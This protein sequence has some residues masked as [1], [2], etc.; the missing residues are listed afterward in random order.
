VP[1]ASNPHG[2]ELFR[3]EPGAAVLTV[4]AR[5][6]E[7]TLQIAAT[8]PRQVMQLGAGRFYGHGIEARTNRLSFGEMSWDP[9]FWAR[10][11]L[12]DRHF[13]LAF[14][15]H[16]R[17]TMRFQNAAFH[18]DEIAVVDEG[19]DFDLRV[20]GP[21]QMIFVLVAKP[22][23]LQHARALLQ[24]PLDDWI[25]DCRLT[26]SPPALLSVC[27]PIL[28][29]LLRNLR[30]NADL[31]RHPR[32]SRSIETVVLDTLMSTVEPPVER[33]SSFGRRQIARR[34]EEYLRAQLAE[35]VSLRELCAAAG[36]SE[37]TLHLAFIESFGMSPKQLLKTLRLNRA[38]QAL[39]NPTPSTTVTDV[40]L[41]WG[42]FHFGRFSIAYRE[43]FGE[44]PLQ[45]L[46]RCGAH[47]GASTRVTSSSGFHGGNA[48]RASASAPDKIDLNHLS[49]RSA[50]SS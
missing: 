3:S 44:T 22:L 46:R 31:L 28:H 16:R 49:S 26:A 32:A 5:D 41:D 30:D 18:A 25:A 20:M 10:G 35:P 42:F 27:G 40:A 48:P 4:E 43:M 19:E 29:A 39:R 13:A 23:L 1:A 34:A 2:P 47:L 14:C 36:T 33:V 24:R 38:R 12:P 11:T 21:A 50:Y 17:G 8:I 15:R 37:R 45:T 9:G 6:V 7:E